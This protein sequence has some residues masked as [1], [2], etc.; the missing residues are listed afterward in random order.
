MLLEPILWARKGAFMIAR[1]FTNPAVVSRLRNTVFGSSLDDLAVRLFERGHAANTVR[2]YLRGAGH[3][4]HWLSAE[5]IELASITNDTV[6]VFIE[7]HLPNCSCPV[8]FGAPLSGLQAAVHH[9]LVVLRDSGRIAKPPAAALTHVGIIISEFEAHLRKNRGVTNGT[10]LVYTRYVSEFLLVRYGTGLVSTGDLSR[11]DLVDF[12]MQRASRYRPKTTKLMITALRSFLRF[13]QMKGF[14]DERLTQSIPTIPNWPLSELPKT[15]DEEQLA[16][17]LGVFDRTTK[18]GLRDYAIVICLAEMGLRVG[19]VT[20]L[21]LDDF[22]WRAGTL[23]IV[24]GKSR[25]DSLLPLPNH[26][27]RAIVAYLRRGRP[28]T[29]ERYVFVRH[30]IPVGTPLNTG[31]V[32]AMIRRKFKAARLRVPSMGSHVLRHT[33]ATRMLRAGANLK[34]LADVLRHRSLDTTVIYAKVDL[35]RLAMVALPWPGERA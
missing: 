20:N 8:P 33:A 6:K 7:E 30:S 3:L 1:Y 5:G 18:Q 10:C 32:R 14:C 22:D 12:V 15:L 34:E 13:W 21:T 27:G 26:V 19:E 23:R 16:T 25:R 28:S 31:I 4:A 35:P 11:R 2:A 17:L 24:A 9:I 29:P